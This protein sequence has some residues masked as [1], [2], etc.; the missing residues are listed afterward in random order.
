[1]GFLASILY[2]MSFFGF[3]V[4]EHR[5]ALDDLEIA[6]KEARTGQTHSIEELDPEWN[7]TPSPLKTDDE[8]RADVIENILAVQHTYQMFQR[9][10]GNEV[11]L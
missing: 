1:M 8:R 9:I 2:E 6:V 10:Y 3:T 11:I 5:K 7:L 4:E